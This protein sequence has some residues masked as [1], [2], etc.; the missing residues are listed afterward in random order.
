[1]ANE[2]GR[3][4]SRQCG[5][6]RTNCLD[7]LDRTNKVQT[8]LAWWNLPSQLRSIGLTGVEMNEWVEINDV[9][10]HD[11]DSMA[12][13]VNGS[14]EQHSDKEDGQH[15]EQ[16]REEGE[17]HLH[18]ADEQALGAVSDDLEAVVDGSLSSALETSFRRLWRVNGDHISIQ[19]AGSAALRKDTHTNE[20][21]ADLDSGLRFGKQLAINMQYNARRYMMNTVADPIKNDIL[22]V[23]LGYPKGEVGS[24][25]ALWV[26]EQMR[27]RRD[28]YTQKV[29]TQAV[30]CTY[31]VGLATPSEQMVKGLRPLLRPHGVVD[32]TLPSQQHQGAAGGVQGGPAFLLIGL[33]R[34]A[35]T[36]SVATDIIARWAE[37]VSAE[38]EAVYSSNGSAAD[39]GYAGSSATDVSAEST[40]G[41][42]QA[43]TADVQAVGRDTGP[44]Q[45]Q[46]PTPASVAAVHDG[47]GHGDGGDKLGKGRRLKQVRCA[48]VLL[49]KKAAGGSLLL[50]F[51]RRDLA[52][53]TSPDV[54]VQNARVAWYSSGMLSGSR[55]TLG[56]RCECSGSSLCFMSSHFEGKNGEISDTLK[57]DYL[58]I[59]LLVATL[60]QC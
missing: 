8:K 40:V 21:F 35:R 37:L 57:C 18:V 14:D 39:S 42:A 44:A 30:I 4:I 56:F 60:C 53:A 3:E 10:V 20:A 1:M 43:A 25:S 19:Y 6:C 34:V 47:D 26:A 7:S 45:H 52:V 29:R 50:V 11:D 58:S 28:E 12:G 23:V 41:T 59:A 36:T 17:N 38:V 32:E 13:S 24:S 5:V 46:A 54:A 16:A 48:Y 33:Q 51:L 2:D 49:V 9:D 27:A 15:A 55:G 31:N 22:A